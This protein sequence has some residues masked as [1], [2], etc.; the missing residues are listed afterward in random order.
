MIEH[1][2]KLKELATKKT[3]P[4]QYASIDELPNKSSANIYFHGVNDGNILM[5]RQI[6]EMFGIAC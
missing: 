4:E 6:L 1:I 5:A 2:N 3:A